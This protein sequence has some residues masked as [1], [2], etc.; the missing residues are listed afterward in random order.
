M[1][2]PKELLDL[3]Q[4][5]PD[6]DKHIHL[7]DGKW[8]ITQEWLVGGFAGRAFIADTQEEAAAE[9]IR[10]LDDHIDHDSIVGKCVTESGWPDLEKVKAWLDGGEAALQKEE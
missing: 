10:Y 2:E 3:I 4:S 1:M 7:W 9:Q 6:A 5:Q 8:H